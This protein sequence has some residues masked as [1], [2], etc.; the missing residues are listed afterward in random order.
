[1]I[2]PTLTFKI[3]LVTGYHVTTPGTVP[4]V[5]LCVVVLALLWDEEAHEAAA[6]GWSLGSNV[7]FDPGVVVAADVVPVGVKPS[8]GAWIVGSELLS[9]LVAVF[10]GCCRWCW[11]RAEEEDDEGGE[12]AGDNGDGPLVVL[13]PDLP[14]WPLPAAATLLFL[15]L[16]ESVVVVVP[17][18]PLSGF[19]VGL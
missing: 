7:R 14:F 9:L 4:V 8:D 3:D 15:F 2:Y 12:V 18:P 19:F 10:R 11:D 13:F 6:V 16:L 17:P 5:A 1:M